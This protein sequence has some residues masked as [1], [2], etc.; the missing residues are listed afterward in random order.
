VYSPAQALLSITVIAGVAFAQGP[1]DL[2]AS[3]TLI[4]AREISEY[5]IS[6]D[7]PA[8]KP[9]ANSVPNLSAKAIVEKMMKANERRAAQLGSFQAKRWYHLQYHGFLGGRDANMEVLATYSAPNTRSFSVLS[10]SGSKL[11]LNRILMKLLDSE[12]RAFRNQKSFQLSPANYDFQLLGSERQADGSVCYILSV[13]ARQPNEFLYNGK[14]WVDA[15]DFAVRR[16]EGEP[17]KSPSFWIKD[18]QIQSRWEKIGNFWFIAHNQSVSHVRMGGFA[19][20][21]IDY[22]YL[23]VTAADRRAPRIQ[24]QGSILPDPASVTPER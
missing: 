19:T 6:R 2:K 9:A 5:L 21:S 18:T 20:L 14:I 7:A 16:M 1:R 11:L 10:E 24:A 15:N 22:G 17:S 12:E 8:A 23:Q 3:A 4:T 13:K